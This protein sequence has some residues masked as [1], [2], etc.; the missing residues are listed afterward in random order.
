MKR[1]I[2]TGARW[3]AAASLAGLPLQAGA[4]SFQFGEIDGQFMSVVTIG[5]M[6]R[7]EDRDPRSVGIANGGLSRSVNEDDGNLGFDQ[8]DIVFA[9]AKATHDLELRYGDVGVM[10]RFGYFYDAIASD[11]KPREER[12]NASGDAVRNRRH[13]EY[14]LGP[15]GRE[16]LESELYLLDL[17]AFGRFEVADRLVSARIG[18]Q[19]VSWGESTFILNSINSINPI[20]VAR[21]RTPGAE[22]KEGLIPSPMLWSSLQIAEGLGIEGVWL[23][24][25]ERFQLD[26]RGSFFSTTDAVSDDGNRAVAGF[27]RRRDDNRVSEVTSPGTLTAY[28]PRGRT[29]D[30]GDPEDQ[31]GVALRYYAE[32]LNNTEFGLYFL[33]YHSRIPLVSAVSGAPTSLISN[34]PGAPTCEQ[35][36]SD[37]N[38]RATYMTEYPSNIQLYGI[39]FNTNGPWGTA[40]QGE[41]SFRPNYPAQLG[42]TEVLLAA[43]SIPGTVP[44]P[45]QRGSYVKGYRRVEA[46]QLQST[47]TKV[48]GPTFGAQQFAVL[49]EVGANHIDLPDDGL[50]FNGPG[51]SLASCATPQNELDRYGNG[52][53]QQR[54]G[55]GYATQT[56]WGYRVFSRLDYENVLGPAS[57]SPRLVFLHDVNGVGPNFNRD[58]KAVTTGLGLNLLQRWQADLAY[59]RFFGGRTYRG[60]DPIA[61]GAVA[62]SVPPG[63]TGE[64]SQPRHFATS[65]N[66]NRDRDFLSLSL[67]YA[68]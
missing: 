36:P 23:A 42:G 19:V 67:S 48:F 37:V 54:V 58:T 40:L 2:E 11:A 28:V 7:M 44:M 34:P 59:T 45:A 4:V 20:D 62:P 26:P 35:N 66:P 8:G 68:F 55:G 53:C 13:G 39:S 63:I 15:R 52:S 21:I 25:N 46:H 27:G 22:I 16:R 10:T 3:L 30:E 51:A 14:E 17:F 64:A 47:V 1:A 9:V 24:T 57:L 56:S 12:L 6:M 41:Y 38:C 29:R 31:W 5:A 60:V 18:R 49:A 33:N 43:V 61:P 32:V 50:V 65:A